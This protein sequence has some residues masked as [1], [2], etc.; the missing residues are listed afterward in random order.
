MLE[1][2]FLSTYGID[3]AE[4][5]A[6]VLEKTLEG[7]FSISGNKHQELT[8]KFLTSFINSWSRDY[9]IPDKTRERLLGLTE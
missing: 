4:A 1:P 2:E 9:S 6:K 3:N 5:D 7:Y 8:R